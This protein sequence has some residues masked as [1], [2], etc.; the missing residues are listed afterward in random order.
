VVAVA[1]ISTAGVVIPASEC[2]RYWD[3]MRRALAEH[4]L[5]GGRV[6]PGLRRCQDELREVAQAYSQ[7]SA[8]SA[9]GHVSRCS[10]DMAAESKSSGVVST[11]VMADRLGVGSRQARRVASAAGIEPAAR[12][13]W[14]SAD[15]DHLID[16]R[17]R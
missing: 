16:M 4:E 3:V 12:D 7:M 9:D 11:R 15:V 13:A 14:H 8:M 1:V 2:L 17:R 5:E 6:R 10:A